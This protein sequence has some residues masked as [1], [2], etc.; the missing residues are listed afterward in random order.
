MQQWYKYCIV[1]VRAAAE[2]LGVPAPSCDNSPV[3]PDGIDD[4]YD[5]HDKR[6][7]VHSYRRNAYWWC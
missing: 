1:Q 2:V 3:A 4:M 7:L 6:A 5:K